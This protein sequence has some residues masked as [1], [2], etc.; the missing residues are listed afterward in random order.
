MN[1]IEAIEAL[2]FPLIAIIVMAWYLNKIQA[3]NRQD[4][5]EQN[6]RIIAQM[7]DVMESNKALLDTNATLVKSID[8]KLDKL[9]ER[10]A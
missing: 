8:I 2:G 3:E 1:I 9:L 5:R 6:E 7:R 4:Q 10:E